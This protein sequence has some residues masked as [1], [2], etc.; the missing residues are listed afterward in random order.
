MTFDTVQFVHS[1]W[2]YRNENDIFFHEIW[3]IIINEFSL[4]LHDFYY[5]VD[6]RGFNLNSKIEMIGN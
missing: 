6:F 1:G 5:L 4:C 3:H 2:P